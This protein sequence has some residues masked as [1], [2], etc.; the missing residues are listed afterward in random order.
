MT[1]A[2]NFARTISDNADNPVRIAEAISASPDPAETCVELIALEKDIAITRTFFEAMREP[3][4]NFRGL[5]HE[6]SSAMAFPTAATL[7]DAVELLDPAVVDKHPT[8][9]TVLLIDR[10][11]L[12]R[13]A[14]TLKRHLGLI[15]HPQF[16]IQTLYVRSIM[17]I[18]GGQ[19]ETAVKELD[20]LQSLAP[21]FREVLYWQGQFHKRNKN[22]LKA[23]EYFDAE[24]STAGALWTRRSVDAAAIIVVNENYRGFTIQFRGGEYEAIDLSKQRVVELD[25]TKATVLVRI[26]VNEIIFRIRRRVGLK[27]PSV[28]IREPHLTET[29][30][31]VDT[32]LD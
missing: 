6:E 5:D 26:I 14:A 2:Q 17:A 25:R 24:L 29:M 13:D 21:H 12:E 4:K 27:T 19:W 32:L 9:M 3:L 23:A 16:L 30:K 22:H 28:M 7:A 15:N 11:L 10:L 8:E 18:Q 1:M 31:A 20:M